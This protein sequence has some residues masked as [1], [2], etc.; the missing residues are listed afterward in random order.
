[1]SDITKSSLV[2]EIMDLPLI[3]EI[4]TSFPQEESEI[5]NLILAIVSSVTEGSK[6]DSQSISSNEQI[7][8]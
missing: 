7:E 1:M 3:K 6:P 4:K 5:D 8:N 2:K